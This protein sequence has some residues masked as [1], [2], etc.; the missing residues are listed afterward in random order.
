[1]CYFRSLHPS[2]PL[3]QRSWCWLHQKVPGIRG[4]SHLFPALWGRG[5]PTPSLIPMTDETPTYNPILKMSRFWDLVEPPVTVQETIFKI[6][7]QVFLLVSRAPRFYKQWLS[8]L[9]FWASH[10]QGLFML[11][12]CKYVS[13]ALSGWW[14]E[15][16]SLPAP[17]QPWFLALGYLIIF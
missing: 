5:Q 12:S 3:V 6:D 14:F 8:L 13:L 15:C 4:P 17:S 11:T 1:M 9:F 2:G 10:F 7:N 16:R